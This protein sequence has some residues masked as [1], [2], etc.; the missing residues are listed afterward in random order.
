MASASRPIEP[1]AAAPLP[2]SNVRRSARR[3][4]A[5]ALSW[6][7]GKD[8]ALGLWTLLRESGREPRALITTITDG[9]DRISMHGA[10]R[11][12]LELQIRC[13]R[14]DVVERDGFVYCDLLPL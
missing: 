1:S 4:A 2:G 14:A 9:Y 11:R 5:F 3:P 6:S 12:L 13:E 7:G 10:R 8:S